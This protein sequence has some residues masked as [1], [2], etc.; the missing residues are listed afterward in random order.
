MRRLSTSS[1]RKLAVSGE[2]ADLRQNRLHDRFLLGLIHDR[3]GKKLAQVFIFLQDGGKK[4]QL[5]VVL[6]VPLLLAGDFEESLGVTLCD[7]AADQFLVTTFS[8]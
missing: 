8:M 1:F 3:I 2:I 7:V 6:F 5:A 4:T